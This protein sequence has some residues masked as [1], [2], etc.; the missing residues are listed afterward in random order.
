LGWKPTLKGGKGSL[1][2]RAEKATLG[3]NRIMDVMK[4]AHEEWYASSL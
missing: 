2:Y 4:P 3:W 1:R